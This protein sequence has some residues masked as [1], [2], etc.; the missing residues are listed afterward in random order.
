MTDLSQSADENACDFRRKSDAAI[1]AALADGPQYVTHLIED[2]R[3]RIY[4]LIPMN[5]A[6]V[7]I[8]RL[9]DQRHT[10]IR[11]L[12]RM[13]SEGDVTWENDKRTTRYWLTT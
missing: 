7:N 5:G 1:R 10:V 2:V 11:A 8:S 9:S 13:E 4:G 3:E 6:G 12:R